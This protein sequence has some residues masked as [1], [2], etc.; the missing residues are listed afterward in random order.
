MS[1]KHKEECKE[2]LTLPPLV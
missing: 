2:S 1:H